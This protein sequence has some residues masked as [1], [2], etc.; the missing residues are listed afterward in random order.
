MAE[1]MS[2]K[3][4]S[5]SLKIFSEPFGRMVRTYFAEEVEF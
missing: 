1:Q 3:I 2:L 5:E 4:F